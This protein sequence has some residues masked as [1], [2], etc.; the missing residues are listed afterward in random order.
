MMSHKALAE[1][2]RQGILTPRTVPNVPRGRDR[3]G[4]VREGAVG[5]PPGLSALRIAQRPVGREPQDHA[6]PLPRE[7]LPQAVQRQ[8]G[9]G[10]AGVQ[11]RLPDLGRRHLPAHH[12]AQRRVEHEA[13]PRPG[14]HAEVG[15]ASGAPHPA[16]VLPA[17]D[18]TRHERAGG[19]GRVLLRR[20]G[21]QR[22]RIQEAQAGARRRSA[23]ASSRA[24]RTARP[25]RYA[26]RSFPTRRSGRWR[27]TSRPTS[28]KA[29]RS[30]ATK[31]PPTRVSR[32]RRPSA[33]APASTSAGKPTSTAWSR[34]GP[35]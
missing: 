31:P 24:S 2:F 25:T 10:H 12:V 7:G 15:M 5:W 32:T 8:D 16:D 20:A 18:A 1:A 28:R 14:H 21:V 29:R 9:H 35:P 22:A 19:S 33:T 30:T 27:A 13:P 6:V 4:V 26:P 17:F 23:R 34:S 11:S 3:R